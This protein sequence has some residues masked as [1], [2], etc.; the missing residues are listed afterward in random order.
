MGL[1]TITDSMGRVEIGRFGGRGGGHGGGRGGWRGGRGGGRW[2]RGRGGGGY[3]YGPDYG[4]DFYGPEF[5]SSSWNRPKLI[6]EDELPPGVQVVSG[7]TSSSPIKAIQKDLM[8]IGTEVRPTGVVDQ[9]TVTA[10]NNVFNGWD[11]A[12]PALRGGDLTAGQIT[13]NAKVVAKYLHKAV[14]ETTTFAD[15]NE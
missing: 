4:P 3:F 13:K 8:R 7:S 11:D 12:P 14:G 10:V 6:Y 15:V 2:S 9:A 1:F 5:Y